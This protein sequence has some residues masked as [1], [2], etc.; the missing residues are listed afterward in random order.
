VRT[1][2]SRPGNANHDFALVA[3]KRQYELGQLVLKRDALETKY[4]R[5]QA[6]SDAVDAVLG[7]TLGWKGRLVPY[8]LGVADVALVLT[9]LHYLGLPHGLSEDAVRAWA[10]ALRM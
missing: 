6:R 10:Q 8:L 3:A 1:P 4:L 2:V 9:A 5:R 7:R